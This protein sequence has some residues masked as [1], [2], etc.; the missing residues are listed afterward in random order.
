MS[1]LTCSSSEKIAGLVS[2]IRWESWRSQLRIIKV[3]ALLGCSSQ[4]SFDTY[5]LTICLRLL[6]MYL[7]AALNPNAIMIE[8][9]P[10]CSC[11]NQTVNSLIIRNLDTFLELTR[12]KEQ[13]QRLENSCDNPQTELLCFYSVF[14]FALHVTCFIHQRLTSFPVLYFLTL[15]R[16]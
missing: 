14:F 6:C 7:T 11:C 15:I 13:P 8:A 4:S 9:I 16:V 3:F 1:P 10:L 12:L 5:S 2:L